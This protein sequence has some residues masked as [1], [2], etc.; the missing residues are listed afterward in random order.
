[1]PQNFAN[2]NLLYFFKAV[3]RHIKNVVRNMAWVLLRNMQFFCRIYQWKNC[4]NWPTF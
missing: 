3:Q 2:F 1:M 4:E